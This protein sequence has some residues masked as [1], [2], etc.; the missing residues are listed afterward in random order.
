MTAV[1]TKRRPRHERD[2]KP[3]AARARGLQPA[4]GA[5][6]RTSTDAEGIR[7]EQRCIGLAH[8]GDTRH[9]PGEWVEIASVDEVF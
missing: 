6:L 2:E 7:F 1:A 8:S 5:L 4:C 9:L 3:Q